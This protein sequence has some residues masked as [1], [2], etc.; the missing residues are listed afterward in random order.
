MKREILNIPRRARLDLNTKAELA[1]HN[2][3]QEVEKA[4]ADPKLTDAIN[5]LQ[6]AR[7]LVA[8]YVDS[9]CD[10][11]VICKDCEWHGKDEDLLKMSARNG[12][13]YAVC[14]KCWSENLDDI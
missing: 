12:G 7:E 13:D 2:A 5:L 1:I 14:P 9:Q 8:D 4:G 6:K 10:S 11:D 3:V